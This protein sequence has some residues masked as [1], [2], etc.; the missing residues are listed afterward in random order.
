M[1]PTEKDKVNQ[2]LLAFIERKETERAAS[3]GRSTLQVTLR[4]SRRQGQLLIAA[5]DRRRLVDDFA[6]RR[7]ALFGSFQ[8]FKGHCQ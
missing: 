2:D 4:I 5:S 6:H 8:I 1:R 7:G 3:V